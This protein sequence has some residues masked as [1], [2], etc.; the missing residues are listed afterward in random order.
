MPEESVLADE[1]FY[2][3]T[4]RRLDEQIARSNALDA[5]TA[6]VFSFAA[7]IL[8]IFGALLALTRADRPHSTQ[9]LYLVAIGVYVVLLFFVYRAY[10][11]TK[12]SL[13]PDL[14]TFKTHSGAYPDRT[15]RAWVANECILSIA[16][17]EP[18]LQIKTWR[19]AWALRLLA[20]DAFLLALA[21]YLAVR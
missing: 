7:A 12:F 11:V 10:Q 21:A 16:A 3:V 1:T 15:M 9:V 5:K 8:P 13:R 20:L 17:N 2:D 19:I 4:A 14:D 6:T 18:Q